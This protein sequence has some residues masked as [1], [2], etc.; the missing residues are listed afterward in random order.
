MSHASTPQIARWTPAHIQLDGYV[1]GALSIENGCLMLDGDD[2]A[3][4]LVLPYGLG[5][6]DVNDQALRFSDQTIRLGESVRLLGGA[7]GR[8]YAPLSAAPA[9]LPECGGDTI[10]LTWAMP[11]K[12]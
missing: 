1:A 11:Q 5:E 12:Q 4:L 6:W 10:L 7:V 9:A 8:D 3:R 2:G